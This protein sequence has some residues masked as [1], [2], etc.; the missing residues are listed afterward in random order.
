[1]RYHAVRA[2]AILLAMTRLKKLCDK[3][4]NKGLAGS[5]DAPRKLRRVR[6]MGTLL[7]R[8]AIQL[9]LLI[10]DLLHLPA[11]YQRGCIVLQQTCAVFFSLHLCAAQ[12]WWQLGFFGVFAVG[13]AAA[14]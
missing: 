11:G 14:D 10:N 6:A 12:M 13:E 7:C 3:A 2:R 5:K 4:E 8:P 1:M 9:P